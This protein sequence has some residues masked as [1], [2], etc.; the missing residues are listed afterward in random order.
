[1]QLPYFEPKINR[2]LLRIGILRNFK[3]GS[4]LLVTGELVTG[5]LVTGILVK[6]NVIYKK[7][8]L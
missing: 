2:K 1:M 5:E 8:E 6:S 7:T 4:L 3:K